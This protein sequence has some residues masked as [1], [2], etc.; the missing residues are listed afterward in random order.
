MVCLSPNSG[1]NNSVQMTLELQ[2]SCVTAMS[3]YLMYFGGSQH[4]GNSSDYYL[5]FLFLS[6]YYTEP[7]CP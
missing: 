4:Y 6:F 2:G 7:I 1:N 3:F 5:F